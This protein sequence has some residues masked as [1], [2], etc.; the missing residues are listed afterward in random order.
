MRAL[1]SHPVH[2]DS[3]SFYSRFSLPSPATHAHIPLFVSLL[4]VRNP[5]SRKSPQRTP[6][7][8][9]A[10]LKKKGT[11]R[12]LFGPQYAVAYALCLRVTLGYAPTNP[13]RL[14]VLSFLY[15][16]LSGGPFVSLPEPRVPVFFSF[17]NLSASTCLCMLTLVCLLG[18][19]V[20]FVRRR[21]RRR[22]PPLLFCVPC[23]FSCTSSSIAV[24]L[25]SSEADRLVPRGC[26][27]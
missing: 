8:Q 15:A 7:S 17:F 6:R 4:C 20:T 18:A 9:K 13:W 16:I 12:V 25:L 10:L 1:L 21:G 2:S 14:P 22:H 3:Y 11:L 27:I 5:E 23:P 19:R 24:A 26:I